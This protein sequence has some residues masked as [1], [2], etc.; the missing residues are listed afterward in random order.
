MNSGR[1]PTGDFKLPDLLRA[2]AESN[3]LNAARQVAVDIAKYCSIQAQNTVDQAQTLVDGVV[4]SL[5]KLAESM[6]NG[7]I[8]FNDM[9]GD[10]EEM[11]VDDNDMGD[12]DARGNGGDSSAPAGQ[13]SEGSEYEN[14]WLWLC[15]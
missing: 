3:D 4:A 5:T 10:D 9:A 14:P 6:G 12:S 1:A 2:F 7:D 11:G 15:S 13:S 8:N